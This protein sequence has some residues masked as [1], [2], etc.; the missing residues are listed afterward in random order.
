[1]VD[2]LNNKEPRVKLTYGDGTTEYVTVDEAS[3]MGIKNI[4][5]KNGSEF[6]S[7]TDDMGKKAFTTKSYN[8]PASITIN[9]QTG[10]IEITAP[11]EVTD[12]P[13]FKQIFNE[14]VLKKYSQAY[15]LNPDYKVIIT[16][17]DENTGKEKGE[18]EVTI[19]EWVEDRSNALRRFMD[20]LKSADQ[21]R[22]TLREK[23]GDKVDK[24]SLTQII[25]SQQYDDYTYMPDTIKRFGG[26]FG[27]NGIANP[28]KQILDKLGDDGAISKA[29]LMKVYNRD[30][31]GR[32]EL[33]GL[34]GTIDSVL[35]DNS[36]NVWGGIPTDENGNVSGDEINAD[37]AAKLI[38]FRNFIT[39]HTPEGDWWQEVG[40]NI[41]TFAYSAGYS[42]LRVFENSLNNIEWVTTGGQGTY[43]Q[44]TIKDQDELM[45]WYV[46]TKSLE[47]AATQT[48][49]TF[50]V[51]GGALA[52]TWAGGKITGGLGS[53]A[54][55]AVQATM[56]KAIMTAA[57][58]QA[59]S[60]ASF[61]LT[62][63]TML[64]LA[65]DS[66]T[67]TKGAWL[68][69]KCLSASEKAAMVT[70][71]YQNFV[72]EHT[73]GQ[74]INFAVEYLMDTVH[75]ALLYDSTTLRDALQST[76]TDVRN[77]WMGQLAD[78]AKWWGGMA[79]A[80]TSFKFAGKTNIGKALNVVATRFINKVASKI[81]TVKTKAKDLV[82]GGSVVR[83]LEDKLED[84]V[85]RNNV[86]TANRL[87]KKIEIERWNIQLRE[88]RKE[89]GKL[90]LDWDGLKLTDE[91]AKKYINSVGRIK[92]LEL[93][94][95]R[96]RNS[97]EYK[98]QEMVGAQIDPSTG[99]VAFINKNL[100]EANLVAS[101][102]YFRLSRLA[103]KYN[104]PLAEHSMI[105]QDMIDYWQSYYYSKLATEF[106]K[107][108]TIAGAKARN[109]LPIIEA[110]AQDAASRLPDEITSRIRGTVD[111]K[112]Y[113][114]YYLEQNE[115]GMAK[116]VL[117]RAKL[118]SYQ[119]NPIWVENGYMPIV[120]LFEDNGGRYI[121]AQGRLDAKIADEMENLEFKV[122][123]GQHYADPELVRQS[124]LSGIAQ[125]EINSQLFKA[126]AGWGSD[127]TNVVKISGEDT[128]YARI[129]KENRA[130]VDKAVEDSARAL[131]DKLK[132][133]NVFSDLKVRARRKPITNK[134]VPQASRVTIVN[135]MDP[136]TVNGF[137]M[138]TKKNGKSY[139]AEGKNTIVDSVDA[140]SYDEWFNQ[141]SP[142]VKKYLVQQKNTYCPDDFEV[143]EY[144]TKTKT[145]KIGDYDVALDYTI[146]DR[147]SALNEAGYTTHNSH[148][149]ISTEHDLPTE[150]K[151]PTDE[152]DSVP[153]DKNPNPN[154]GGGYIQFDGSLEPE[155]MEKIRA[156]AEKAGMEIED[157]TDNPV[158]GRTFVVRQ[159]KTVD[160]TTRDAIYSEANQA[161]FKKFKVP[162][163]DIDAG[164]GWGWLW[165]NLG[166]KEFKDALDYSS[167]SVE[168]LTKKHGGLAQPDDASRNKSWDK[169]FDSLGIKKAKYDVKYS[170]FQEIAKAG[171]Q[172]FENGL[173]RA[174]LVG[175]ND[176]AKSS[177]M[178]EAKHNLDQGKEAFYQG[179]LVADI[180]GKLRNV[181]RVDTTKL[182]DEMIPEFESLLDDYTK[183]VLDD[184]GVM[185]SVKALAESTDAS[186]DFAR[187]VAI[188]R[189]SEEGMD[190]AKKAIDDI[191]DAKLRGMKDINMEDGKTIREQMN[192]LFTD[193]VESEL[194]DLSQ[195]VRTTNPELVDS[196]DIY[197]KAKK[198]DEEIRG[199]DPRTQKIDNTV[200]YL[201]DNGRQVFAE[202]DP[203]FASL[204]NYRFEMEKAE[205]GALAKMNAVTSRWFRYGT[206]TV[207]FKS[208][209]NQ[210]FRD[211]GNALYIGGA[212]QTIKTYRKNLVDVFGANIVDQI[213]RFDPS[214]YEMKQIKA[215]ADETGQR[216]EEAAV[217]RELMRG[218]ANA[219]STTEHT[220]YKKFMREAYGDKEK[221]L[222][223]LKNKI[224]DFVDEHKLNPEYWL[225]D[226]RENYLRN[227]V[228][229]HS[230]NDALEQ[231]Y[232]VEQARV[233]ADFAMNNATTNFTRQLYH[234]QAIA[235]STPYFRAAI[236]GSKSFWR[237]WSLDPVGISGRI[238]GGLIIPVMYL[239]GASL[240]SEENRKVYQNVPEYQ[241]NDSLVLAVRGNLI[242]FPLPQE[243]A[244][245]IAPYRQFVE[246]L[247][248]TN[249]NDFWELMMNDALGFFP[250]D[251]QGFSTIDM[252][253]M[254]QDPTIFDRI[255]RGVS[256]IFAKM[257][258]VPLKTAYM[259]ATG[260]DP[261]TG[262]NLRN[263]QYSYW[264]EETHS[265][266]TQDW[267]QN[268]F[269]KWFAKLPFVEHWMTPELAEKVVSGA[270]GS[271]GSDVL[272]DITAL[273]VS[274]P[275]GAL[276]SALSNMTEALTSPFTVPQYDLA[277]ATWKRAVR[278]LTIEKDQLVH[279]DAM[280]TINKKLATETDPEEI[281]HLYAERRSLVYEYQQKVKDT[282]ERLEHV[283]SGTF[284]AK[285]FAAT[286]QLLNFNSDPLYQT[287]SQYMRDLT[288]D[289]YYE[290]RD[291]AIQT[292]QAL[293][294][295]G[296]HDNSIFGYLTK[297]KYGNV[298]MRYN[299]P[300]AIM[301]MEN[302]WN[303]QANY[304][305]ANIKA[306]INQNGLWD[307][308]KAV[309][310]QV[311]AI[312]AKG[313][314]SDADYDKID[315]IYV[316]WNAEVMKV[317]APYVNVMTPE[318]AINNTKTMD[319]IGGLIKIP[320]D[321]KKDKYGKYVTNSKLGNG[322][323]RDA[324]I[325]GYI[326]YIFGVNDTAYSSGHNYSDRKNYDKE[327]KR[328]TK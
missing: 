210:L 166:S 327:N 277:E 266:E 288:S 251:L 178:N 314:L 209:G 315:E 136:E 66:E 258:P 162:K 8:L 111:R 50:G 316:N 67:L 213:E 70:S 164:H 298:V 95:D 249:P 126:Y 172:D 87:R 79:M 299:S 171:G 301:D 284:G 163:A 107:N 35:K 257:A 195:T 237:M 226:K 300:I 212:W 68:A 116:G 308:K 18:K 117:N 7:Y 41:E 12:L 230:Y 180:K 238:T 129:L 84:A 134:T 14:D 248:G 311:D 250:Y 30:N 247:Y 165:D 307:K 131:G 241:K 186:A 184:Q 71:L 78:N 182:V 320:S 102:E 96:Y 58:I 133:S 32:T 20:Q 59:G 108:D 92:A 187:Y 1:M 194:D 245:L 324:Y 3:E 22:G 10:N 104:L 13:E 272:G 89:L 310:A 159:S 271:T 328:W 64:S 161:T 109:A 267:N 205:A 44:N 216:L 93:G 55:K 31:F 45:E 285:E 242:S 65:K 137:L 168:K 156:A 252:D 215:L 270:I 21:V 160:G 91:S 62:T 36:I 49:Y 143:D 103:E 29:D 304:H 183:M 146:A 82:H 297:D 121:E 148:S 119:S 113:Q 259:L 155:K 179:V 231:G 28:F 63:Q 291:S 88:A 170:D 208:F 57:G 2:K 42:A 235:D 325:K 4:D 74:V 139:I 173:E 27:D 240:G 206:T 60:A 264:N 262:K 200:M 322:S 76:D 154:A 114:S 275:G 189:L 221:K 281:E 204:Y 236:N 144:G 16:E 127:A 273:F 323:A 260:T 100:G 234:L 198:L 150:K 5:P 140:G 151:I 283:Y 169:F 37:E 280:M 207:N 302:T 69:I 135:S 224:T 40:G 73:V 33:A 263:P 294:I 98:R 219:P 292:M 218:A 239:V 289:V 112:V 196:D 287:G 46:G 122:E 188:R 11:K 228:F 97:I 201:D 175:D 276:E 147:V 191:I 177:L 77:F 80:K 253:R 38:A 318:A 149:G 125:M 23:Y 43:W 48:L 152:F 317:L 190:D 305:A 130:S 181:K 296:V 157:V 225:N 279:S 141:Q 293:G 132:E 83:S 197:T 274:G 278:Q 282:V 52:A 229:A 124:R 123:R 6:Y 142:A 53:L 309:D 256:R 25:M 54:G 118:E 265:V 217:S 110:N 185:N 306:L 115:Y 313:N 81:G 34:V 268:E 153:V 199:I 246:Y 203:A 220:L 290:G 202:V 255:S 128:E 286:I 223:N 158:W 105:S 106:A 47:S 17:Y 120:T 9:Q 261:Y 90:K 312:Y 61:A 222:T 24:L 138:K 56:G 86:K 227:R 243:I 15:K 321:F 319:Y 192:R 269:A 193:T 303:N 99:K 145:V 26:A 72:K 176:F 94:I 101:E 326:N 232:D 214:G 167:S 244:S 211:F 295:D 39:S 233:F 174:T 85:K 51:I 75:D 254:I 19:P